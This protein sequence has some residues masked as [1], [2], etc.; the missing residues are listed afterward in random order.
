MSKSDREAPGAP[1]R[2]M[3]VL[4]VAN[5][6]LSF[7]EYRRHL[8]GRGQGLG[9][10]RLKSEGYG[11]VRV[12]RRAREYVLE[13]WPWDLDPARPGARQFAGWPV[14]LPFDAVDGRRGGSPA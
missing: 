14:R 8:Q 2:P 13:C 9:D 10:R 6:K 3:R 5:P 1:G 11:I 4:A 7:A 12:D